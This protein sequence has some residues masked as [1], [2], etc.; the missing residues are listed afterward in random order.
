MRSEK[1]PRMF[2]CS[3][4][5]SSEEFSTGVVYVQRICLPET[6]GIYHWEK[7]EM[8]GGGFWP[9]IIG[10]YCRIGA[11][12]TFEPQIR[13]LPF[14]M[15]SAPI[16]NISTNVSMWAFTVFQRIDPRELGM[17]AFLHGISTL[18]NF[19]K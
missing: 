15:R 18:Q 19:I 13:E 4:V 12:C 11:K 2:K 10:I 7:L 16:D 1:E 8:C 3:R 14:V 6:F 17:S 9:E 5:I